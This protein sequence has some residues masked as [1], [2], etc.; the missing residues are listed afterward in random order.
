MSRQPQPVS[1]PFC[2]RTRREFFWEAGASF[3]GLA[4]AGLLDQGFFARQT[5]AADGTPFDLGAAFSEKPTVLIFY[6]GGWC[7]F[8]NRELGELAASAQ[9][10]HLPSP[11]GLELQWRLGYL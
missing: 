9:L 2:R 5:R 3:T 6:R 8:C 1:G 11:D 10:A 4:L 7:P